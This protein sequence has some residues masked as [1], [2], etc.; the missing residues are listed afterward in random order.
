MCDF[1]DMRDSKHRTA[2]ERNLRAHLKRD[3]A[4]VRVARMSR[5]SLIEMTRQRVRES[6]K[7]TTYQQCEHCLGT[8]YVKSIESVAVQVLREV[9]LRFVEHP[10]QKVRV[11]CH[12]V[13]ADYL[14]SKKAD[15]IQET[16]ERFGQEI[17]TTTSRELRRD[18]FKIN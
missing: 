12:P 11:L 3:R 6:L 15:A 18:E 5:F 13:V 2:V 9:R 4:R 7:R 10:G 8:G 16:S 14:A 17:E 1:I